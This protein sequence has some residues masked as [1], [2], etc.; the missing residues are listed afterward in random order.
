MRAALT[1]CKMRNA[2]CKIK[3]ANPAV[4]ADAHIRP[5]ISVCRAVSN[6]PM[7]NAECKMQNEGIGFADI[8]KSFSK[9]TPQF[10][11]LHFEFCI[12]R[13]S[14]TNSNLKI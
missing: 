8:F 13:A 9:G 12:S 4:G 2:K 6:C 14:A 11:T 7:Q 5:Q 1:K 10:C 3:T